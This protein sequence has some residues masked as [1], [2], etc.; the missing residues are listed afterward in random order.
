VVVLEDA[1]ASAP[2]L[3]SFLT[4]SW[5]NGFGWVSV[6]DDD[7]PGVA[8]EL[9]SGAGGFVG[10]DDDGGEEGFEASWSTLI[11]GCEEFPSFSRRRARILD[12]ACPVSGCI[13]LYREPEHGEGEVLS[14]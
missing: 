5:E 12:G 13:H 8:E 7:G 9:V 4:P 1:A 10:P 6:K 14:A 2:E 11:E 3:L